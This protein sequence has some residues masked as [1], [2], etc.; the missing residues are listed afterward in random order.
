MLRSFRG[1]TSGRCQPLHEEI[2]IISARKADPSERALHDPLSKRERAELERLAA[3][4]D[5][6]IDYSDAPAEKPTL[7]ELRAVRRGEAAYRRGDYITLEE[8]FREL[9]RRSRRARK[10][11][12]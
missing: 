5:S 1:K 11:G 12:A 9:D 7:R 2:R 10:K 4:P 8:Y 6:A 3:I